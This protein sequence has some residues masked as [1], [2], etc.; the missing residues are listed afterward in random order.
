MGGR[1]WGLSFDS[2]LWSHMVSHWSGGGELGIPHIKAKLHEEE[3]KRKAAEAEAQSFSVDLQE[4]EAGD[5]GG[6]A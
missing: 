5:F 4:L 3:K 1:W 6:C 2:L